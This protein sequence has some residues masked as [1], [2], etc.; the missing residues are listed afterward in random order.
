MGNGLKRA[1]FLDRDGTINLDTN[2]LS[3]PED[4]RLIPGAA[5]AIARLNQA[6]LAV[7]VI[8]NQ[9]G[10]ARDF[11]SEDDLAA[12]HAELDR[13]L[14]AAGAR[15]DAYF[16]CPHHP[17]GVVRSLAIECDCR[18]PG[19]GLVKRA[20]R[21]L[22]LDLGGSFMIG[23]RPGDVGCAL[24]AGLTAVRVLSGPDHEEWLEPAHHYADD[25]AQA[26]EWILGRLGSGR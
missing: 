15:I 25:L 24:A 7:V 5:R 13:L 10:L 17:Q 16:H 6:R 9:S 8:T 26:V 3:S 18:K 2:Y 11:F 20:A 12:V 14:A 4:L 22:G 23:D 19:T 1:V 21:E